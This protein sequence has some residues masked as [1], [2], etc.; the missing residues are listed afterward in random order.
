MKKSKIKKIKHEM[1]NGKLQ[2]KNF[3]IK[4]DNFQEVKELALLSAVADYLETHGIK[5]DV[6]DFLDEAL[7]GNS[8]KTKVARD[9][10]WQV[11]NG[12]KRS[13]ITEDDVKTVKIIN[14]DAYDSPEEFF[15]EEGLIK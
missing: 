1:K 7:A 6:T 8:W 2:L 11:E 3:S 12:F 4:P 9:I 5:Q 14:S 10:A 13:G 15:R